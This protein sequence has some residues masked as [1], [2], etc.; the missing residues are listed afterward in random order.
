VPAQEFAFTL[1]LTGHAH[2]SEIVTNVVTSVLSH[3]GYAG[4]ALDQIVKQVIAACAKGGATLPC[5]V[6]FLAAAGTLEIVV[7]QAGRDWRTTCPLL[8]RS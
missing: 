6:H 8:A 1:T 2:N 3:V 5:D 7:S 4:E